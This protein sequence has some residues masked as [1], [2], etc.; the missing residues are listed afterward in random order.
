M[1]RLRE[2]DLYHALVPAWSA[3][4]V[5]AIGLP[6][7]RGGYLLSYD[8]VWVPHLDLDRPEMWGLGSGLPRAVPSDAVVGLLGTALP[9]ALVQRLLLLGALFLLALG[10]ARLVKQRF[11]IAQL[12]AATFAVWNPYVAERLVLGQWPVLIALAGVVWLVAALH[13]TDEPRWAV[14]TL[15]LAATGI[16]PVTGVMGVVLA[17]AVGWRHGPVRLVLLAGVLNGPWIVAGILH[18]SIARTDPAA[19]RLF[20]V[21]SEGWF[22]RLGSALSLGGIWNTEV[23]PTSRTLP[24]AML[25]GVVLAGV[26]IVGL[27]ALW[28][29]DRRLLSGLAL[30]GA[31][32]LA[33]ALAGWLAP[34]QVARVIAD[35]PG[36]GVLRD[37]TRWLALLLPL[38]AVAF[39]AGAGAL[40]ERAEFTSWEYPT[41]VLA[42]IVPLA[43]LPDLAWGVGGRVEPATYPAS[44]TD[45]RRVIARTPVT[46]DVLVLP[47]S[48]YR[49]PAWND[50]VPVL[51]PAGR[52]FDRTTV[53][54]DALE[55]S[56]STIAGEDP[57]AARIARILADGKKV[58][59]QLVGAGIGIV[60]VQMDAPGAKQAVKPF[61]DAREQKVVG[62]DLRVFALEDARPLP[63]EELDRKIMI[64]TWSALGLALLLAGLS[65]VRSGVARLHR[66][67]SKDRTRQVSKP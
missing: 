62:N 7:L 13:S 32:G 45:A 35:V 39:G 48:S 56:G 46:G 20:D 1:R 34:D 61:R 24:I 29:D 44:W 22:G 38:E 17:L 14:V 2:I 25:I 26:M 50:D 51:D 49:R 37:G 11:M 63:V 9:A 66:K 60:V 16:S 58:P 67:A 5:L 55:V 59:A 54:N 47:F 41:I 42:L 28:H 53:T 15:A 57:R 12:A 23:V 4:L 40:F 30:A 64:G 31:I 21:Q 27:F 65:L 19:V 6:W 52:F 3:L 33:V 8:M 43:A 36:G 18:A 10:A